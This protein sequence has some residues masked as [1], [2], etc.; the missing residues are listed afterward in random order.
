MPYLLYVNGARLQ[1]RLQVAAIVLASTLLCEGIQ[2][3]TETGAIESFLRTGI[4]RNGMAL[5]LFII[6]SFAMG[7][8]C[9]ALSSHW[10]S[11]GK[12]YSRK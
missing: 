2:A 4:S 9:L 11:L 10:L 5:W 6:H 1:G 8:V 7:E 12:G 3:K